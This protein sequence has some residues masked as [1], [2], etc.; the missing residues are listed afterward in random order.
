MQIVK[1]FKVGDAPKVVKSLSNEEVA[2]L[3][4]QSEGSQQILA[5]NYGQWVMCECDLPITI[6]RL[7]SSNYFYLARV[8]SRGEHSS[9]CK[10]HKLVEDVE[11]EQQDAPI[12]KLTTYSFS[13]YATSEG[14]AKAT[15]EPSTGKRVGKS[16]KLYCLVASLLEAAET[17][18][19][20]IELPPSFK[21]E[22]SAIKHAAE[23]FKLGGQVLSENLYFGFGKLEDAKCHL[24]TTAANWKGRHKPQSLL[25]AHIDG[26]KKEN[27][28]WELQIRE[29]WTRELNKECLVT[30][31]NGFF[32][33]TK[34][35]LLLAGIV[36]QIKTGGD[37]IIYDLSRCFISPVVNASGF[38][39]V[40]SL[41]ERTAAKVAIG[42]LLKRNADQVLEKPLI[43]TMK[44]S[45][46]V[47][48]D[49]ILHNSDGGNV[50][51]VMGK[52]EDEEY[53]VRKA[54]TVP[55]MESI[56]GRVYTLGTET[57]RDKDAFYQESLG[58]F[59]YLLSK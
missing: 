23:K 46:P 24:E 21:R 33:L 41:L 57:S 35:P 6:K 10:F 54:R 9:T 52:W 37:E 44:D 11:S 53:Q 7:S 22:V 55:L 40:D 18:K 59:N 12:K 3:L 27:D 16:D 38:M 30:R 26:I 39:L 50:I 56:F 34:G 58:L 4:T 28:I 1:H 20:S 8:P 51:E 29:G 15:V 13:L 43:P 31:S 19:I 45:I 17:N 42:S 5:D 36:S 32:S 25:L 14:Q 47:L 48:P 2:T 49:F